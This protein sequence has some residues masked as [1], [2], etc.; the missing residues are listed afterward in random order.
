[1]NR[2]FICF[3]LLTIHIYLIPA[4]NITNDTEVVD[5]ITIGGEEYIK[6]RRQQ[7]LASAA[8]TKAIQVNVFN[9]YNYLGRN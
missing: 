3:L 2:K 8:H 5:G 6:F 9:L 7:K 1:M 4:A